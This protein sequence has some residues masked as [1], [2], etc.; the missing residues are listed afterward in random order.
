MIANRPVLRE[1][2]VSLPLAPGFGWTLDQDFVERY[3]VTV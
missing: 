2:R 3:R 1:G